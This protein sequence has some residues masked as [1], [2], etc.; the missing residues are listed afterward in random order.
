MYLKSHPSFLLLFLLPA[1]AAAQPESCALSLSGRVVDEHDGEA[2]SR[3]EVFIPALGKGAVADDLG[4]FRIEGICAGTYTV[5]VH[6]VGCET[7]TRVLR[8]SKDMTIQFKLEHHAEE[9]KELEVIQ[10]RPDENVGHAKERIVRDAMISAGGQDL[11]QMLAVLP[12]V[13]LLST[14]PSIAK[15]VIHGLSGNRVLTLNQGVRQEDQQWGSDHAPSIDPLSSDR[16]SVVKGAAAVQYGSDAIGG[17]VIA[18]PVE[19]PRTG[20]IDGELRVLGAWNGRGG[21]ASGMLQGGVPG[22]TGLGWRVQGS[23]RSFGDSEAPRYNLSNTGLREWAGSASIG[24][25]DH[26]RQASVYYSRFQREL[27][28][29]R[30]AHIGSTTDLQRAIDS[31]EPW[32]VA[33]FTRE[34]DAPRQEVTH[35][36]FKAQAGIAL[37]DLN[38]LEATYGY[39][40][41]SRQEYDRRRGGR[42][43]R[44]S[45][46]LFLA[47]HTGEMVLKHWLGPKVHGKAGLT[48]LLQQNSN[49]PGTGV[50]PFLPDYARRS[51]GAFVIEHLPVNEE[52]ELEAGAR[53][54]AT[55]IDVADQDGSSGTGRHA[56][57]NHALSAG[58]HWQAR[59]SV[60]LRFNISSAF[61]PPHVSELYAQG[62]HHGTAS[63]EEG[64]PALNSERALKAVIEGRIASRKRRL[65]F[66]ATLHASR[67]NDFIYLRPDGTR[68]TIRG[69]FPVFRYVATDAFIAGADLAVQLG[70]SKGLITV[71]QASTV[72]GRDLTEGGWLFLMPSDRIGLAL[73]KHVPKAGAWRAIE[74]EVGSSLVIRQRRV[75]PD[76]DFADAPGTYHL[77]GAS[78]S[79]RYPVGRNELRI[80]LRGTNLLN[81][82]YRDYL[83]RLRYYADA[84]GIDIQ[85]WLA[86]AF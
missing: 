47:T 60:Q 17:V 33:D 29:L 49:I 11:A 43:A 50:T 79:A 7:V 81:A 80:G 84:R 54:E 58:A 45:L 32:Y 16:L 61:R 77:L 14:G 41:N 71:V 10:E 6:H 40:G 42:S 12:G 5:S 64:D 56:F 69:A 21:G 39:Q 73:R 4:R 62:M 15:P 27:G 65:R 19:L 20:G 30:A 55:R 13:T 46:D 8:I 83:D 9:L 31:G 67:I 72:Q 75:E 85:L 53:L 3:A 51:A 59:D 76:L 26:R 57:V 34:I 36:L 82:A 28:I 38:R 48:G 86:F 24:Y 2:L 78:I 68:L 23:G 44:P 63:I 74:A 37:T 35:H 70:L 25:W 22:I 52:L 66:D 18:E 1:L